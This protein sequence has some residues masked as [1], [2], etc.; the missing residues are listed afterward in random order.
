MGIVA[1]AVAVGGTLLGS[2]NQKDAAES[3]AQAAADANQLQLDMYNQTNKNL[4]PFLNMGQQAI[5][6][7]M[8]A[9]QPINEEQALSDYY[10]SGSYAMMEEQAKRAALTAGE[11]SGVGG[12]SMANNLMRIS[13][14]MG[15]Q[16][17]SNLYSQQAD[18]FNRANAVVGMG[19]NAAAQVGTAGQNYASQAGANMMNSANIMGQSQIAQGNLMNQG[20]G[21]L[22]GIGYDMYKGGGMF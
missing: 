22:L 18:Q 9:M 2:K 16:H 12:S 1:G 3:N 10:N 4:A 6:Q 15:Q 13:P 5:P 17:L 21:N 14:A 11:A 19:Q 8:N 7:L 20:M